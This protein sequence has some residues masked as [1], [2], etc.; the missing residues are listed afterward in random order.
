MAARVGSSVGDCTAEISA[1]AAAAAAGLA[2]KEAVRALG[3]ES[4]WDRW[5]SNPRPND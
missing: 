4:R 5:H 1:A 2:E 3:T